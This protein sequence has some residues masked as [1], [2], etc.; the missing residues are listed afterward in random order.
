MSLKTNI[1]TSH[2]L[3]TPRDP[4]LRLKPNPANS[5]TIYLPAW[6][7][8]RRFV[9]NAE[10]RCDLADAETPMG[11]ARPGSVR[12]GGSRKQRA[13]RFLALRPDWTL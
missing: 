6:S 13:A 3:W 2:A 9:D 11:V 8:G 5:A 4:D 1:D 7:T 12:L 10:A